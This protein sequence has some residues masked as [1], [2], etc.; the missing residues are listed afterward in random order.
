MSMK[1][2]LETQTITFEQ[3]LNDAIRICLRLEH[4]FIELDTYMHSSTLSSSRIAVPALLEVLNVI[5]RPDLKSK[6]TQTLMQQ[7]SALTQLQRSPHVNI[8]ELNNCLNK[9]NQAIT[10]LHNTRTKIGDKLRQNEFLN[11]VRMQL[12]TPGGACDFTTPMFALWLKQSASS[13][14]KR[15]ANRISNVARGE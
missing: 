1:T 4:L 15:V 9:L 2:S 7:A 12:N 11:H 13:S 8:E 6:L 3:P 14:F 5:D 10:V